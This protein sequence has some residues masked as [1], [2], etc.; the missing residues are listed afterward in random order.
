MRNPYHQYPWRQR[1]TR[2]QDPIRVTLQSHA[3]E[4]DRYRV[5]L[6]S[7]DWDCGLETRALADLA[8]WVRFLSQHRD[9]REVAAEL[10]L[11]TSEIGD[12]LLVKE[13]NSGLFSI[14]FPGAGAS[15]VIKLWPHAVDALIKVLPSALQDIEKQS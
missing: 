5:V 6:E 3:S 7:I 1:G 10:V 2:T 14:R 11:T 15:V 13:E 8:H 4:A 12:V 9:E